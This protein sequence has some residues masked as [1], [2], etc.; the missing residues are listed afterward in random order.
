VSEHTAA[1]ARFLKGMGMEDAVAGPASSVER[2]ADA[3]IESELKLFTF[4]RNTELERA[5]ARKFYKMGEHDGLVIYNGAQGGSD[6]VILNREAVQTVKTL[7]PGSYGFRTA[8]DFQALM[9]LVVGG[10]FDHS[11][12]TYMTYE[13]A[14]RKQSIDGL[15]DLI[16]ATGQELGQMAHPMLSKTPRAQMTMAIEDILNFFTRSELDMLAAGRTGREAGGVLFPN[17]F[18]AR[19]T[20]VMEAYTVRRGTVGEGLELFERAQAEKRSLL[21]ADLINESL[22][23]TVVTLGTAP[24]KGFERA[25]VG[26]VQPIREGAELK[27][28]AE[29]VVAGPEVES[30]TLVGSSTKKIAGKDVDILYDFGQVDMGGGMGK[31]HPSVLPAGRGKPDLMSMEEDIVERLIERSNIDTESFDTFIKV[32]DRYFHVSKSGAGRQVIENTEYAADQLGRETILL[33][34]RGEAVPRPSPQQVLRTEA[35]SGT[36]AVPRHGTGADEAVSIIDT[37][38]KPGS[39]VD[40][41]SGQAMS[42]PVVI[43]YKRKPKAT[44]ISI[45]GEPGM[46]LRTT[47]RAGRR[48]IEEVLIDPTQFETVEAFEAALTKIRKALDRGGQAGREVPIRQF[49]WNDAK[50]AWEIVSKPDASVIEA[51]IAEGKRAFERSVAEV[52]NERLA[53]MASKL[54]D[55]AK[56]ERIADEMEKRGILDSYAKTGQ[57]PA[58]EAPAPKRV[59]PLKPAVQDIPVGPRPE[60]APGSIEQLALGEDAVKEAVQRMEPITQHMTPK[61]QSEVAHFADAVVHDPAAVN[62]NKDA[63]V[64][65]A[66]TKALEREE[67]LA[68]QGLTLDIIGPAPREVELSAAIPLAERKRMRRLLDS[69]LKRGGA[70][71][72]KDAATHELINASWID[73]AVGATHTTAPKMDAWQLAARMT[74]DQIKT[75]GRIAS[76]KGA[77][78]LGFATRTALIGT[79]GV[80]ETVSHDD[81]IKPGTQK[82]LRT[83]GRFLMLAGAAPLFKRWAAKTGF[84]RKTI[85][86]YN[87]EAVLTGEAKTAFRSLRE[88]IMYGKVVAKT[89]GQY[90]KATFPDAASQRAAMYVL[91][92]GSARAPEY[93]FLTDVQRAEAENLHQFNLW[94]GQ[95]LKGLGV[96]DDYV[97]NYIRRLLPPETFARWR[98]QG[99]RP[100]LTTSGSFTKRRRITSLRELEEWAKTQKLP[101]PIMDPSMVQAIHVGEAYRA[102]ATA[103]LRRSMERL[104]LIR[105]PLPE[106][107]VAEGIREVRGLKGMVA[108][109]EVASAIE[110]ISAPRA[111]E[112]EI[113]NAA[114]TIKS[115]WMR[116]IMFWF[117][118][119]GLNA[120]RA[121][122][123]LTLNPVTMSRGYRRAWQQVKNADPVLM[124]ASRYGL[125]PF[126]RPDYGVQTAKTFERTISAMEKHAPTLRRL[127]KE[128]AHLIHLQ[129]K[130]LWDRMVPALGVFAWST[131]MK[132]WAQT[133]GHKF[134]KGSPEYAAAARRSADFANRLMGKVPTEM[135]N[136]NL[137]RTLRLVLFSPSWSITRMSVTAHAAGELGDMVAGKIAFNDAL[138]LRFK[139]RQLLAA[140]AVTW[141]GSKLLSGKEP[142]YNPNT[143]KY[144]MQT[145][146]RTATGRK[147]GIDLIGWWQDDLKFFN[148]PDKFF[149]SR[150][151]PSVRA[152]GETFD[153]RDFVGRKMTNAQRIEN[154]LRSFGPPA[155]AVELAVRATQG[156]MKA[157]E[158]VRRISGVA[159]TGNVSALPRPMDVAISEQAT[160]LLKRSNIPAND[161]H[162]YELVRL[163]RGNMMMGQPMIDQSVMNYLA[164]RR[165]ASKRDEPL[166]HLYY[167]AREAIASLLK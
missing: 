4:P 16:Y 6:I 33:A 11:V 142:V 100:A 2:L 65:R 121:V 67:P 13:G 149:M 135:Q 124:E 31:Q 145:K 40:V 129:D 158:L 48:E 90:L 152:V 61:L 75:F 137:A 18:T 139:M 119:H 87:P 116:S 76:E 77:T 125:N 78:S 143:I 58:G 70:E 22:D 73:D 36:A 122:P 19:A 20:D 27:A 104:G 141:V 99:H 105:K 30:V 140:V 51:G 146:M 41:G 28:Y 59:G 114:D 83:V 45:A 38:L 32:N 131:E 55:E 151:N 23:P 92:E 17:A 79:G 64:S 160:Q 42:S 147:M 106:E 136:P 39:S 148:S 84:V 15:L 3:G 63:R 153:G 156:D 107:I 93:M 72:E 74:E 52:S 128:G 9:D 154:L 111:A 96:L 103:N 68:T 69:T 120:L 60:G 80:F 102:M 57:V 86:A 24:P 62:L 97:E 66:L 133:T 108:P 35:A 134:I 43:Q 54:D 98:T 10:G 159:A 115:W 109:K 7:D 95:Q 12:L 163:M 138:N 82:V 164:Y 155:E 113:I 44:D 85:L 71:I 1:E 132:R 49:T 162:V 118:E 157:A 167:E 101:G 89:Q 56:I 47:E 8:E 94:L 46:N 25:T 110:N 29:S 21:S 81:D 37:G 34:K 53:I 144:Y 112:H 130:I 117:W 166:V 123:G 88:M 26:R 91:D 50:D 126:A 14:A 161:D 127:Q 5:G 150:L 165:R